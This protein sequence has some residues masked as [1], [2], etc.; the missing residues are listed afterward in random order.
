[1]SGDTPNVQVTR[2]ALVECC[3]ALTKGKVLIIGDCMLDKYLKG[4]ARRI[5]PEAPVPVVLVEEEMHLLGGAGNVARNIQSLGGKT[6]I[7]GHRGNDLAGRELQDCLDA[8][9]IESDLLVLPERPTTVKTRVLARQQQVIRI[10]SESSRPMEMRHT[11]QLLEKVESAMGD[12]SA[13]VVSDYGKGVINGALMR[14]LLRITASGQRKIPVLV[15]PKPQN[16]DFYKNTTLLTPNAKETSEST[17]MPVDTPA[18]IIQAGRILMRRLNLD[19][20]VTTLGSR[21]L[22][23]FTNREETYHIPT[24]AQKVYDVTGAGDTVIATLALGLA[25]GVE[26]L[27]ACLIANYAAGI[28]VGEVGAATVTMEHLLERINLSD[29]PVIAAWS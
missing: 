11:T 28:V 3:Q 24:L 29:M 15:D 21:G 1:M 20:L 25:A 17:A 6:R 9:G 19:H 27:P 7:I 16:C 2:Q 26:L 5:S 13:V 8:D 10:D 12:C 4:D 22:A 18:A 14:G 23:V